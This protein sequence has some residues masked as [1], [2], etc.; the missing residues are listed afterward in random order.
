MSTGY[1]ITD[2][3]AVYFCTF[4]AVQWADIFTPKLLYNEDRSLCR[5]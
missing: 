4:T 3:E 2:Q 5:N 1:K